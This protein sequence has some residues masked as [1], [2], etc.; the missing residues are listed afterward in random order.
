MLL[1]LDLQVYQTAC[2]VTCSLLCL[3]CAP[4]LHRPV[5]NNCT[6]HHNFSTTELRI[7][8]HFLGFQVHVHVHVAIAHIHITIYAHTLTFSFSLLHHARTHT[9]SLSLTLSLSHSLTL[10]RTP[11]VNKVYIN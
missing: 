2:A 7:L 10:S 6:D 5:Y 11:C 4:H 9:L 1:F 3:C 8:Q